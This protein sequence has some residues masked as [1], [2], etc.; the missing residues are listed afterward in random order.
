M[1]LLRNCVQTNRSERQGP[2]ALGEGPAEALT[3]WEPAP[4]RQMCACIH[5]FIPP[6]VCLLVHSF[7]QQ[8]SVSYCMPHTAGHG[9]C[10]WC[11]RR[12]N[13]LDDPPCVK[14]KPWEGQDC[15]GKD[16]IGPRV[17]VE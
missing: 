14:G 11:S 3:T 17:F 16:L 7:V 12:V 6:F 15:L 5:A 8:L 10:S 9:V 2:P 1:C 13:R 4:E